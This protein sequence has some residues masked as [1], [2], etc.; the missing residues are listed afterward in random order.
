MKRACVVKH[1][2][3]GEVAAAAAEGAAGL[4]CLRGFAAR[5]VLGEGAW[6]QQVLLG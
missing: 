3:S 5:T 4:A 2:A 6:E 1:A